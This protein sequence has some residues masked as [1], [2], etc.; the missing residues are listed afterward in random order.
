MSQE[1]PSEVS[2]KATL[3]EKDTPSL[4]PIN[5]GA[6]RL[7]S[8]ENSGLE[9]HILSLGPDACL[10]RS[11]GALSTVKVPMSKFFPSVKK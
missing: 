3:P 8:R 7:F 5:E 2:E 11:D 6:W 4:T 9:T 1:N 10:V